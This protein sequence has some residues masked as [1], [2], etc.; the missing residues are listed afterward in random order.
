MNRW[1]D[2]VAWILR[3]A[4]AAMFIWAGAQKAR[5]PQLFAL[6]LE[7]YRILPAALILPIAYYVPWLEIAAAGALFLPALRRAAIAIVLGLLIVFT[8]M[9]AV[10]WARGL[11]INCG[12]F[13]AAGH[14]PTD[15]VVAILRNLLLLGA[16]AWLA[17][18]RIRSGRMTIS[19]E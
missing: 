14:D 6:D 9:L 19:S 15:F 10:A 1:S 3:I 11:Q 13:G 7:A 2:R 16:T 4:L 8:L 12:C 17:G 5:H 18:T